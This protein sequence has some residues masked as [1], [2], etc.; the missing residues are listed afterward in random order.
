MSGRIGKTRSEWEHA[1]ACQRANNHYIL[2][3]NFDGVGI[4][5]IHFS[6]NL[7]SKVMMILGRYHQG[8][9]I[10]RTDTMVGVPKLVATIP[11]AGVA[12]GKAHPF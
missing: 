5:G 11:A 4:D 6:V 8:D 2:Y 9:N 1:L 3:R 10:A 7:P 12:A